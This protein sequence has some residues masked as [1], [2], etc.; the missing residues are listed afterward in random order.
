[1]IDDEVR[2]PMRNLLLFILVLGA[3]LAAVIR[4]RY[5]GGEDYQNLST[6]PVLPAEALEDVLSYAQ[7]I[8][9][10][11]ISTEG[12][13]F[14]TVHPESRPRGNRLLEFVD[15]ASVPYPGVESQFELFDT[16]LGLTV[17]RQNR[18]WTIDHGNHGLRKPRLIAIDLETNSVVRD[19]VLPPDIA[20][21]GSYLQDLRVSGDG[22]TIVIADSSFWR[23]SP[24]LVV[25]DIV[26]GTA[27]RVLEGDPSVAAEDFVV[28][29]GGRVRAWLGGLIALKGGVDGI[30]I[31]GEWLYYGA[32]TGSGVYR[33]ALADLRNARLSADE[34]ASRAERFAVKPLSEGFASNGRDGV[35]VTDVEHNS[36]YIIGNDRKPRTLLQSPRIRWPDGLATGPDGWLYVSDSALPELV[37]KPREQI[38]AQRPFRVF[39]FRTDSPGTPVL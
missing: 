12:R 14:F 8:G 20:P 3:A 9:N 34:L 1:L 31:S 17:D 16:V 18:L 32:L 28:H 30:A 36:V 4:F 27:R 23:Q 33:I 2:Q 19:Q 5:G 38:K 10:V 6:P 26:S 24:A 11:A 15:G 25:Y 39:R 21:A 22:D 7:P 37:L 13:L 35:Y 29:N